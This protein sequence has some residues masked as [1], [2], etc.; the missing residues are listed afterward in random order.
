MAAAKR[1]RVAG[2][3]VGAPVRTLWR[4]SN[5]DEVF[6][7]KVFPRLFD[8]ADAVNTPLWAY[9]GGSIP[10]EWEPA[11]VGGGGVDTEWYRAVQRRIGVNLVIQIVLTY[12][13]FEGPKEPRELKELQVRAWPPGRPRDL[14][15]DETIVLNNEDHD[16]DVPCSAEAAD[17][18]GAALL[19][20]AIVEAKVAARLK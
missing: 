8:A 11:I 18:Y 7:A 1:R 19:R 6:N 20:M 3:E 17:E 2:N 14:I 13:N 16:A 9:E 10:V 5:P 15:V 12:R 4:W